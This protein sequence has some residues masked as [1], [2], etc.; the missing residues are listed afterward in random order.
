VVGKEYKQCNGYIAE[1]I[2]T[3]H[4]KTASI[5]VDDAIV[6][7][8]VPQHFRRANRRPT[9]AQKSLNQGEDQ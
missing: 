3:S 6:S 7:I 4:K 1:V 5:K 2:R 8:V 9:K